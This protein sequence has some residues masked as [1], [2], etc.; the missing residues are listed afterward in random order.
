[1]KI[2]VIKNS[3]PI[4]R[5]SEDKAGIH[6]NYFLD[7]DKNSYVIGLKEKKNISNNLFPIFENLL[8]EHEQL[9]LIKAKYKIKGQI[10]P[11]LHLDN[12]HG[13]FEFYSEKAFENFISSPAEIFSFNEAKEDILEQDYTYPNILNDY[14]V[15]IKDEKIYPIGL[16]GSKAIGISGF[17]YKFSISIDKESKVISHN[18]DEDGAYIMK[19]YNK[20]NLIY[21][22][23]D[24]DAYIPHLLVNEHIFMTL[25][26]DFG[27]SVPYNGIIKHKEDYLYVIKRFDRYRNSK[28]DHHE[29]LTLIG[30]KSSQ[31]YKVTVL[32]AMKQASQYLNENEILEMF[33]FFIFSIVISHGDLH[34]KN[35]SLIYSSNAPE[36]TNMTL[37]PYYDISTIKIYKDTSDDDIGMM[38]KN[39]KKNIKKEDLIWL[40]SKFNIQERV[41]DDCIKQ[42]GFRF[43]N[44]F[45][46]YIDKLPRDIK[47]L[48]IITNRYGYNKPF[49]EILRKYYSQRV[50]YLKTHLDVYTESVNKNIWE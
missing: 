8:P 10:E 49:E 43:I 14:T 39:K 37:A 46:N 16:H 6:F 41:A 17:Q 30:K 9:E 5:L 2:I 42:I 22:S 31:K 19:P 35:I 32:E 20:D 15:D 24:K 1:M 47:A 34:A 7:I 50:S 40:A 26:R 12:I 45:E 23:D 27:F 33:K 28:I 18:E 13:S 25:A 4:G 3:S 38:L 48:K 21:N 11:L 44:E 29:I 36:E